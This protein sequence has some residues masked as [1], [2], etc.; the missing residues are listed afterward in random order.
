MQGKPPSKGING[1][2]LKVTGLHL[3]ISF[4]IKLPNPYQLNPTA[5]M[6]ITDDRD[7]ISVLREVGGR[8]SSM[9]TRLMAG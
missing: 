8:M 4:S 1:I 6:A 3:I 5:R 7:W 2:L 9:K